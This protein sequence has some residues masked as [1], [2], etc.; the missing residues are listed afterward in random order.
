MDKLKY[1][2]GRHVIHPCELDRLAEFINSDRINALKETYGGD[3]FDYFAPS[4]KCV[5]CGIVLFPKMVDGVVTYRIGDYHAD[6]GYAIDRCD[7]RDIIDRGVMNAEIDVPSGVLVF[8]NYFND[9]DY[10]L[11]VPDDEKYGEKYSLCTMLGRHNTT[12]YYAGRGAIQTAH[13]FLS[14]WSWL[15]DAT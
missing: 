3:L 14:S 6:R 10:E 11:D 15:A 1:N 13:A 5:H 4:A 7:G 8:A 2:A 12:Q 9:P